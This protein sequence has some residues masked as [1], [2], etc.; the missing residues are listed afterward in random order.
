VAGLETYRAKRDFSVTKEP[1]GKVA[2]RT[3]KQL[4]YLIQRHA[5]TRLHY[6]FRLELEGILKSWAVTKVP[7]LDP[8]VKRLAVEVEDH[9]LEYGDFE[10]VIP[11]GQYGGGTVQIW[12]TGGWR[13]KGDPKRD[14]EKGHLSFELS[15]E[16]LRGG[17]A[18]IRMRD[19]AKR[20]GQTVR[21][22]WLLIKER[23]EF[24]RPGDPDA[25]A[26]EETSVKTGRTLDEIAGAKKPKVWQSS[27]KK[28]V[29]DGEAQTS[30]R[31][32]ALKKKI[33]KAK[34]AKL[35]RR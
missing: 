24:A 23:D 20:L 34:T 32:A 1:K 15:G 5:A 31:Q 4:R 8:S 25:L 16:R 3:G 13:P 22:N 28:D 21:H 18:L 29:G 11:Q 9:P 30:R 35:R 2:S 14:L 7:S 6:D 17:W 33:P 27:R 26:A 19:Q 12:D 10:G